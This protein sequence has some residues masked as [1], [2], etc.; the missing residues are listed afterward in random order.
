M[1]KL[2]KLFCFTFLLM[3]SLNSYSQEESENSNEVKIYKVHKGETLAD[4]SEMMFG[5]RSFWP[6]IWSM[7]KD[8]HN[9]YEIPAGTIVRYTPGTKSKAPVLGFG[10]PP[11]K[12]LVDAI[13]EI[14]A[15]TVNVE[16]PRPKKITSQPLEELPSSLPKW[17][18]KKDKISPSTYLDVTKIERKFSNPQM[19]LSYYVSDE[20]IEGEAEVIGNE[21]NMLTSVDYQYVY[22][23]FQN[24]PSAKRFLVIKNVGRVPDPYSNQKAILNQVQ[25][26]VE[27]MESV[28]PEKQIYRA[29]VVKAI[30]PVEKG[31]RLIPSEIPEM[32]T[33]SEG[34]ESSST[35][36][37]I[38][39]QY[40]IERRMLSS[41]SLVFLNQ[42]KQSGLVDGVILPIYRD[43]STRL[44]RRFEKSF[45]RKIGQMKVVR[46]SENV[47]TALILNVNEEVKI[48]DG[49][50]AEVVLQR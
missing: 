49:A 16:I 20:K 39:G 45:P 4:V 7:N 48:G 29:L 30:F 18:Y 1:L 50:S 38:G 24:T 37:I 14:L 43:Q 10:A 28:D 36:R 41:D 5:D 35:A 15:L 6:Q 46:V 44:E 9:P 42:G 34:I 8:I 32:S 13:P 21:M 2:I 31:S 12:P 11:A 25:G 33:S 47:S 3:L 40:G 17:K 23:R 22:I 26:L 27:V 19:I